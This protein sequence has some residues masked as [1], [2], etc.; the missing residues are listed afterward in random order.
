M[1]TLYS[2]EEAHPLPTRTSGYKIELVDLT[3]MLLWMQD[4]NVKLTSILT[5]ILH[6]LHYI[7]MDLYR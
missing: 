4:K 1:V 5:P 6:L 7:Y 2:V 3:R